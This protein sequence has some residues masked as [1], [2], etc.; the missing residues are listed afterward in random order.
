MRGQIL[1]TEAE[2]LWSNSVPGEFVFHDE[3]F[4]LTSPTAFLTDAV[5][6]RVHDGV[7]I[8]TYLQAVDPN[9]VAV[10]DDDR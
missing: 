1:V 6:K 4:T 8:G 10:V 5:T 9:V 2:P 3:R 7:K